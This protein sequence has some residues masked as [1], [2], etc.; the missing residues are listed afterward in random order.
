M[1]VFSASHIVD[2][3]VWLMVF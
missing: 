3:T 2:I 1:Y